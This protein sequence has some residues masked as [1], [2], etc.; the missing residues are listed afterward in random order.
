M[1]SYAT[2]R[3]AIM[4]HFCCKFTSVSACQKL[5]KY[6]AVRQSYC[7]NKRVHFFAPQCSYPSPVTAGDR[8]LLLD[9]TRAGSFVVL[10][11]WVCP[12]FRGSVRP[13]IR[14]PKVYE[15]CTTSS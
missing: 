13:C 11:L 8:V 7:K 14:P 4:L 1:S 9:T 15:N 6:N 2:E 5:S 10:F 12:W 3:W